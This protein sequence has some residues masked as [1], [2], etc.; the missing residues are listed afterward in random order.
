MDKSDRTGFVELECIPIPHTQVM[1][2][3]GLDKD[4]EKVLRQGPL[5]ALATLDDPESPAESEEQPKPAVSVRGRVPDAETGSVPDVE[6]PL[7][8]RAK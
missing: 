2:V 6:I 8:E 7:K 3:R 5:M 4:V 1:K